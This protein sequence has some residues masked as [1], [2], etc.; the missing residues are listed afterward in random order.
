MEAHSLFKVSSLQTSDND[1]GLFVLV[2]LILVG[3][4]CY[5]DYRKEKNEDAKHGQI[6]FPHQKT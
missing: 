6:L 1:V 3:Y 2:L 5:R 4:L